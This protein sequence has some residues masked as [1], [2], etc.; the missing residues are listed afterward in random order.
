M[1]APAKFLFDVDFSAPGRGAAASAAEAANAAETA[2]KIAEAEARGAR[3][4]FAKGQADAAAQSAHRTAV[5]LEE[6]G[7]ALGVVSAGLGDV[8]AQ[9]EGEAVGIAVAVARKLCAELIGKEPLAEVTALISDCLRHLSATPHLVVRINDA[10]YDEARTGIET[11]AS[12]NGFQGRL[13]ILSD[14]DIAG[15]D[16]KIEWADGGVT[17]DQ[18]ATN[19]KI[20]E[21]V[22]R[23]MASRGASGGRS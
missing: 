6:I 22:G 14:P 4:G 11:L 2:R 7:R 10:L 12:Q 19:G 13:V 23:Y 5:A 3:D 16:C 17:R 9:L 18:A 8:Q 21:L 1:A 20:D 15:G